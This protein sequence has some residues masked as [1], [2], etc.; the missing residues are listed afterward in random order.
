M[1]RIVR[2]S[3]IRKCT[4]L[5]FQASEVYLAHLRDSIGDEHFHN[6][7]DLYPGSALSIIIDT[8]GSMTYEIAAVKAQSRLIVEKTHPELYILVPYADPSKKC[9]YLKLI[10]FVNRTKKSVLFK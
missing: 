9:W 8:T 1:K 2:G 7:L 4:L 3:S 10:E 5:I 6:L